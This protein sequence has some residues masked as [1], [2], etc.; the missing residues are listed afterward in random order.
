M[1]DVDGF[2]EGLLSRMSVDEKRAQL[3]AYMFFDSFWNQHASHDEQ[4]RIAYIQA[5]PNEVMV[6]PEGL[7]FFSTQLRDLPP[8]MAAER[9]NEDQAYLRAHTRHG[10]PAIIQ[11]EG[12]HG[13]IGHSATVFPSALAMA[14]SWDVELFRKVA[15]AIGREARARG[16]RQLLSPTL[17][18]GR[19]PRNGRTEETYG[20]DPHLAARFAVAYIQGAQGEGV[21]CT[22][23]HFIANFEADAGRDSWAATF[24]ERT[25]RET[26]LPPFEAAIREGGALSLMAA[27][28]SNDGVPCSGNRWLLTELLRNEWGFDGYVVSDY[29]S[30]VHQWELHKTA[31]DK[32]EAAKVSLEAGLDVEFPRFD[33]YGEPLRAALERG[34][35]SEETIT[36]AARRVLRVKARIGIFDDP[37]VDPDEAERMTNCAEHRELAREMARRSLVLL[38]NDDNLLP[39]RGIQRLAVIGPNADSIELGD[40][41]WDLYDKEHVVTPLAGLRHVAP[42]LSIRHAAGCTLGS[43]SEDGFAEALDAAT[44]AEAVVLFVGSSVRLTGE[45]RDRV[46]LRLSSAQEPLINAIAATGKPLI[47]CIVT[48]SVHTMEH[49]IDRVPAVLQCWYAGEEGGTAIAEVLL[50]LENPSGKLPITIPRHVGQCPIYYN[51]KPSGRNHVYTSLGQ[52]G[53]VRFEFGHG[54]SYA[55]F[56]YTDISVSSEQVRAGDSVAVSITLRNDGPMAGEEVVQLYLSDEY[57]SVAR[58]LRELKAFRRVHLEP[59]EEQR[60]EFLLGEL[61]LSMLDLHLKRV[62]EPGWFTVEIGGQ[63]VRFEVV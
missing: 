49:W 63:R 16:V 42:E 50:G 51:H 56:V 54:L 2:V 28:N 17:N 26:F 46:D 8:R 15:A 44:W 61:E 34:D 18:L 5:I 36:E 19:D 25:L 4:A 12:L 38:K 47:V 32:A 22:P 58:P 43:D 14:A 53:G 6:P 10:I 9:A 40:Y 11:D 60:V 20:E 48:G 1:Q 29:H 21:V 24:S 35:V 57:A 31:R 39:L 41:S 23:K 55:R 3:S 37:M 62:V 7:G 27:Y 30:I 59:G 33:C 13:L 52:Q 45:A